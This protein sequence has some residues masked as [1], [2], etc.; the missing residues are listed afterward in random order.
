MFIPLA[1]CAGRWMEVEAG[2]GVGTW[3]DG[4]WEGGGRWAWMERKAEVNSLRGN[5]DRCAMCEL[6]RKHQQ[7][8]KEIDVLTKKNGG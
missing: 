5:K 4:R 3:M 6:F 7:I 1:A 8:S 2:G